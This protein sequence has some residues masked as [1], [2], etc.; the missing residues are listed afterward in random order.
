MSKFQD[1][2]SLQKPEGP[3][4]HFSSEQDN[5]ARSNFSNYNSKEFKKNTSVMSPDLKEKLNQ[6][7][8]TP[9]SPSQILPDLPNLPPITFSDQK[10]VRQA[11][12]PEANKQTHSILLPS[13]NHFKSFTLKNQSKF[14]LQISDLSKNLWQ[15]SQMTRDTATK[16]GEAGVLAKPA[17][18]NRET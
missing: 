7:L 12:S 5:I 10:Q 15:G 4:Y 18:E 3:A 1:N 2:P 8:K 16:R 17:V 11:T 14:N 13:S 9:S 6:Y